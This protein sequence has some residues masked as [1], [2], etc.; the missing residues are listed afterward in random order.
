M[1]FDRC[2]NTQHPC[3]IDDFG[4]STQNI[5]TFYKKSLDV[6]HKDVNFDPTV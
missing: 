2:A 4:D 6:L 3:F 5:A 1:L